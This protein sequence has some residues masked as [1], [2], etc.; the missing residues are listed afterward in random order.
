MGAGTLRNSSGS[1]RAE[2]AD[3]GIL[4]AG[5]PVSVALSGG[6]ATVITVKISGGD[7]NYVKD[8]HDHDCQTIV[9]CRSNDWKRHMYFLRQRQERQLF[10]GH[11]D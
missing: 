2:I 7:D 8:T 5:Q 1:A 6:A 10:N 4:S 3:S 11:F 9:R